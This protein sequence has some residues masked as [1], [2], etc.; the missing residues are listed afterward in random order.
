M[1]Y[2]V[3]AN[4]FVI[5]MLLAMTSCLVK[6]II[7]VTLDAYYI[8]TNI[9]IHDRKKWTWCEIPKYALAGAQGPTQLR[10]EAST[11]G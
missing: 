8:V 2:S 10:A 3:K 11:L 1:I 6:V 7:I 5:G 4:R 9:I